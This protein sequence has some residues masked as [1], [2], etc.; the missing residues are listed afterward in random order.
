MSILNRILGLQQKSSLQGTPQMSP[1]S[2]FLNNAGYVFAVHR[3]STREIVDNFREVAPLYNAVM[4]IAEAVGDLPLALREKDSGEL[5][6]EHDLLTLLQ[7]PNSKIQK[8]KCDFLR[9]MAIWKI[10]DGNDYVRIFARNP[11]AEP[12]SLYVLDPKFMTITA[13]DDGFPGIYQYGTGVENQDTFHRDPA[14]GRFFDQS[15]R[16]ELYHDMN[17]SPDYNSS[18]LKGMSKVGSLWNEVN[19]YLYASRHN[20]GLLTNGARPSGALILK[21][22]AGKAA[23]LS[24][25]QFSRLR[26]DLERSISG[27]VNAGR[28]I[29]LEGGMEWKEMSIN[30]K[31]MEFSA[32]KKDAEKQ[33]Y[34]A[35]GVPNELI[36]PESATYNNRREARLYFYEDTVIPMADDML[37][38]IG[39]SLLPR[40]PDGEKY[41]LVVDLDQVKA[42]ALKWEM[43]RKLI[44]ESPIM[45]IAEKRQEL[46]LAELPGTNKIVNTTGAV[47]VDEDG[48]TP[49]PEPVAP[50]A[51]EED[52]GGQTEEKAFFAAKNVEMDLLAI[53]EEID[54]PTV[55]AEAL[56]VA[57]EG[58]RE[59]IEAFGEEFI[60]EVSA[61]ATF[62]TTAAMRDYADNA[63]AEMISNIS[64]TTKKKLKKVITEGAA[65]GDGLATVSLGIL[66]AFPESISDS[67]VEMIAVTESTRLATFAANESL[68]QAGIEE[69]EWLT[70]QDGNARDT[71]VGLDGQKVKVGEDFVTFTGATASG[72]GQFGIA[73]ED[74]NCRCT[75][76]AAFP[77]K[78]D[79]AVRKVAWKRR[80]DIREQRAKMLNRTIFAVFEA[81]RRYIKKQL[82]KLST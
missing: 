14:T 37:D 23:Q 43:R 39:D 13:Q 5:V 41:D 33:I 48:S 55:Y 17:F 59:V 27:A 78:T 12:I 62:A 8:T 79:P 36:D 6:Y 61:E 74:I 22:S 68:S 72:P 42:L 38:R 53:V 34:N 51:P 58:M 44:E 10:L 25:E 32:N 45:T 82:D 20:L 76:V 28:P 19:S 40:Y 81:Q 18:N 80:E 29:V 70:V 49:E 54:G 11:K 16:A 26:S 2:L 47:I 65:D 7:K 46:G 15:K 31:D 35:L 24:T 9:D 64:D 73:E 66:N 71:H 1:F 30:P 56:P 63:A 75:V 67:R 60:A 69:K 3:Y 50:E 52:A 21:D 77:E 57:A 4:K